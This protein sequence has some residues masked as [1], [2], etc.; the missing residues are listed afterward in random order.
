MWRRLSAAFTLFYEGPLNT[1]ISEVEF[2]A[3][4]PLSI[5]G[6]SAITGAAKPQ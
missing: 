6:R 3:A 1:M 2:A 5:A 4:S